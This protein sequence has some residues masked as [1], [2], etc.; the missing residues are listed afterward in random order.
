MT[1]FIEVNLDDGGGIER[2]SVEG[3]NVEEIEKAVNKLQ[4]D[5]CELESKKK[6]KS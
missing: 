2:I 6:S 5:L 3:D 4:K 1:L